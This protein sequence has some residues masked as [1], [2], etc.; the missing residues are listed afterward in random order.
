M[1]GNNKSINNKNKI[2]NKN[3]RK[4]LLL[5]HFIILLNVFQINLLVYSKN[6]FLL[7]SELNEIKLKIKGIGNFPVLFCNYSFI[8]SSYY[9]NDDETP[10]VFINSTIDLPNPE[11]EVKLIFGNEVGN[12]TSMFK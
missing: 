1:K 4:F 10:R 12:C 11:N 5:N 3:N 9:L 2:Y 6:N 8:P 7:F